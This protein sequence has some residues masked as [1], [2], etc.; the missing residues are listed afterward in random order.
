MSKMLP[1]SFKIAFFSLFLLQTI[2]FVNAQLPIEQFLPFGHQFSDAE[3]ERA[4]D[5]NSSAIKLDVPFPFFDQLHDRLWINT[6]G[7]ITFLKPLEKDDFP[8]C[9]ANLPQKF[10][11]IAPF[12]LLFKF[13]I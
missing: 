7:I 8:D 1:N 6:N 12:W 13:V 10:Q 9:A 11:G 3:L 2:S 5:A 4:D